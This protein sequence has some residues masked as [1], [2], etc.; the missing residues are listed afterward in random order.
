MLLVT[1]SLLAP[2][3]ALVVQLSAVAGVPI[4]VRDS[5]I[6]LPITKYVNRDGNGTVDIVQ[7]DQAR[8]MNF[9]SGAS[10]QS[11]LDATP[12]LDVPVTN[13]G[14]VYMVSIGVG[15]PPFHCE[16]YQFLPRIC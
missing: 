9:A 15:N 7:A 10:G 3:V 6:S 16:S 1:S 4:A 12:G 2:F 8:L 14:F 11:T 5:F 13:T